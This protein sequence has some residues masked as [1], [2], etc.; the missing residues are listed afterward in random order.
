MTI[1]KAAH[2]DIPALC[3]LEAECFSS[4]WT[5]KGFEDSFANDCFVCYAAEENG[6]VCGYIGA[7]LV[8]GEAEI[9]N[10]AVSDAYRRRG[11][12]GMLIEAILALDAERVLLD[13]RAS[14]TA[15]RGLYEKYGFQVDGIRKGFYA[16]PKEDA[17]LMSRE[18]TTE[19]R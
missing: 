9:T 10:V 11:I 3:A 6:V 2:A 18:R 5:A 4:P 1:R 13:V 17:V 19:G 15:A 12:G 16:K 8:C 7:M 14:N